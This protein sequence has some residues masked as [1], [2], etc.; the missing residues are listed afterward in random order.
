MD[1]TRRN[2][3][4]SALHRER[5]FSR[6]LIESSLDGI[7]AFDDT[8]RFTV[9]NH[10][11][12]ELTGIHRQDALGKHVL[13]V[14][15]FLKEI[16]QSGC[17]Q[18]ALEGKSVTTGD[19]PY[20]ITATQRQGFFEARYTPIRADTGNVEGNGQV[21][22][23]LMIMRDTTERRKNEESLRALSA[24]LLHIQDEERRRIAR[25]LHDGT[26]QTLTGIKL[27]LG[28]LRRRELPE[29]AT[30]LLT[31]TMALADRALKEIRTTSYLLHPPELDLVGLAPALRS[32]ARGFS[33]RTGID[34]DLEISSD[35]ERLPADVEIALFRIMQEALANVHRHSQSRS[36]KV[37]L[38]RLPNCVME[39]IQDF[40]RGMPCIDQGE[41][42]A[43]S[44]GVGIAGMR[45][46]VRELKGELR[47]E[48]SNE[49]TVLRVKVPVFYGRERPR[50]AAEALRGGTS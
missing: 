45:A 25:E 10:A 3:V 49:G 7:S 35:L 31:E 12:E 42:S 6:R 28:G 21:I 41:D 34:T 20:W 26:T 40:G 16:G 44:P 50:E 18:A 30:A 14:L 48:S 46:R 27:N 11:M 17:F 39:E 23:G 2:E 19:R 24:R 4:E 9:W 1:V 29:E 33:E 32:Y 38:L 22:G 5:E 13:E 47:I 8:Y 36:A 37:R 15:P 43:A